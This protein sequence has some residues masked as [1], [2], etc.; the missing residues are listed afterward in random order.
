[1]IA[2]H[3]AAA[4]IWVKKKP[5]LEDGLSIELHPGAERFFQSTSAR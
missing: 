1:L 5:T 3:P 4:E 2:L